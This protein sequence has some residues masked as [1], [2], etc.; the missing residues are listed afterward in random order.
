MVGALN[1]SSSGI[2]DFSGVVAVTY[3]A[4]TVVGEYTA[5]VPAVH[6]ATARVDEHVRGMVSSHNTMPLSSRT[7]V[8]S[9]NG[10]SNSAMRPK[11]L[12]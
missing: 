8:S 7:W 2:V 1:E 10:A 4:S 6:E 9:S 3:A 5:S 11:L 12:D